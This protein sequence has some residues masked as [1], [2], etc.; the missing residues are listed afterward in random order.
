M[1]WPQDQ[2]AIRSLFIISGIPD[3]DHFLS[4][5]VE[6]WHICSDKAKGEPLILSLMSVSQTRGRRFQGWTLRYKRICPYCLNE[7]RLGLRC[8]YTGGLWR[9]VSI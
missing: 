6:Y 8:L 4:D 2:E 3:V 9:W 7:I 5:S 1:R